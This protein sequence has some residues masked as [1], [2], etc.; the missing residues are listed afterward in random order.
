MRFTRRDET[1]RLRDEVWVSEGGRLV[2]GMRSTL[3][4]EDPGAECG[5]G[6]GM[7]SMVRDEAEAARGGLGCEMSPRLFDEV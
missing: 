1:S 7:R 4:D 2:C 5:I 6:C 3:R